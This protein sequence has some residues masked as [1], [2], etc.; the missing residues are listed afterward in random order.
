MTDIW[1]IRAGEG[2]F[3]IDEFKNRGI[4]SIGW[5]IGDLTDKNDEDIK[6]LL[7]EKYPKKSEK[8]IGI[9]AKNIINFSS[10]MKKGDYVISAYPKS[11]KYILGEI[12][13]DYYYSEELLDNGIDSYGIY[14]NFRDVKWICEIPHDGLSDG[15]NMSLANPL[16]S[17]KISNNAKEEILNFI[18]DSCLE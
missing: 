7:K 18:A 12:I 11:K 13:S 15:T 6:N 16:T 14:D 1:I 17:Y 8:S 10:T 3:L 2:A 4:V 9:L 5:G